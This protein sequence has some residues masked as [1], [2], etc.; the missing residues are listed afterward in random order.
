MEFEAAMLP[1][2]RN[3]AGGEPTPLQC[4]NDEK[5]YELQSFGDYVAYNAGINE[6]FRLELKYETRHTGN[7]FI[8]TWSNRSLLRMGWFLTLRTDYL[9]YGFSDPDRIVYVVRFKPLREWLWSIDKSEKWPKYV[10]DKYR[11]VMQTKNEQGNDT[12]GYLVPVEDIRRASLI[13]RELKW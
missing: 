6:L 4:K 13:H 3:M 12:W 9:F 2:I 5:R 8:E 7:L 1:H 10:I 11:F